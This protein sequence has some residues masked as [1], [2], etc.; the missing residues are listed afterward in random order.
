M[1]SRVLEKVRDRVNTIVV[2]RERFVAFGEVMAYSWDFVVELG[3][4]SGD[5]I[6]LLEN[7]RMDMVQSEDDVAAL[8]SQLCGCVLG[9]GVI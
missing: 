4:D 5:A 2:R 3:H 1:T 9:N 7:G 6:E 8:A